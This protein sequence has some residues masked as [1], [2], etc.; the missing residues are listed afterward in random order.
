MTEDARSAC[1][2]SRAASVTCGYAQHDHTERKMDVEPFILSLVLTGVG[3]HQTVADLPHTLARTEPAVSTEQKAG[4]VPKPV[5]MLGRGDIL[6]H[7]GTDFPAHPARSLVTLPTDLSDVVR[8]FNKRKFGY[9][10]VGVQKM[11]TKILENLTSP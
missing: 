1:P 7:Q 8:R 9:V 4:R 5:R 2:L 10:W 11:R 6:S 3:K